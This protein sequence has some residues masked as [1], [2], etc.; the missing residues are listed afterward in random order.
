MKT[1]KATK[2]AAKPSTTP[3]ATKSKAAK[4][5]RAAKVEIFK[6][7]KNVEDGGM[8]E[9]A[10]TFI[11]SKGTSSTPSLRPAR[12][13]STSFAATCAVLCGMAASSAS[14]LNANSPP[15]PACP[16]RGLFSALES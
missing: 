14:P 1:T 3:A 10:R 2:P 12:F 9:K 7:V 15:Q 4:K 16:R 13:R 11:P 6:P 5:P 8:R